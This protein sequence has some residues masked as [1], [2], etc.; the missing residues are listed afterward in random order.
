MKKKY[1]QQP[2]LPSGQ[3]SALTDE[4]KEADEKNVP[5]V[6][7]PCSCSFVFSFCVCM[8]N[9]PNAVPNR[10]NTKNTLAIAL[11]ILPPQ[12]VSK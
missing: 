7:T 2:G 6:D 12:V 4:T 9:V 10:T 3:G 8:S 11:N 1:V 5:K